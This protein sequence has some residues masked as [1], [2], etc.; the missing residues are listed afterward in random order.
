[1]NEITLKIK[2]EEKIYL[3]TQIR[4]LFRIHPGPRN[5]NGLPLK[6]KKRENIMN[7]LKIQI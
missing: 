3:M 6:T 5:G 4:Q 2:K 7:Y 1:M